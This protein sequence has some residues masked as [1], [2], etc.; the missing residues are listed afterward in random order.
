MY[1]HDVKQHGVYINE[2][3]SAVIE[4]NQF[5]TIKGKAVY[6]HSKA[7]LS[8]VKENWTSNCSNEEVIATTSGQDCLIN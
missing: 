6:V 1:V 7:L 5:N 4:G 8:V 3:G 2:G